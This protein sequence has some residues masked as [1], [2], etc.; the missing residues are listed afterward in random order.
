MAISCLILSICSLDMNGYGAADI[1]KPSIG[2]ISFRITSCS[3]SRGDEPIC[4][5]SLKKA[6]IEFCPRY[7][8]SFGSSSS[9]VILISDFKQTQRHSI[10][11]LEHLIHQEYKH[12]AFQTLALNVSKPFKQSKFG[13]TC[14][15]RPT[16]FL[17]T[18]VITGTVWSSRPFNSSYSIN[19]Y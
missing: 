12:E 14:C 4:A 16:V 3:P 18:R 11:L 10:L 6:A 17:S 1:C 8:D 13:F 9:V 7:R 19:R 2:I 15:S 5:S